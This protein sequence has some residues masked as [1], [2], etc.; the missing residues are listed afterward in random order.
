VDGYIEELL[1]SQSYDRAVELSER[2]L[3]GDPKRWERWVYMFAQV[4]QLPKLVGRLPTQQPRL[5]CV[6]GTGA[7][8]GKVVPR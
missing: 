7:V 4:R 6:G 8:H 1:T 5:R 2:L 3:R